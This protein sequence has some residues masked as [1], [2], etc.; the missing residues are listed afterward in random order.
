[1][2]IPLWNRIDRILQKVNK[3]DA[4]TF[5]LHMHCKKIL[6]RQY[7]ANLTFKVQSVSVNLSQFTTYQR[8]VS[9]RKLVELSSSI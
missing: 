1:M 4:K 2:F 8:S 6:G 5:T 7:S 3:K 9:W